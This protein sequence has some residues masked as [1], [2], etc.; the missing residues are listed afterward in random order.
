MTTRP[1]STSVLVAICLTLATLGCATPYGG[2]PYGST[3]PGYYG[4]PQA[5]PPGTIYPGQPIPT[6]PGTVAPGSTSSNLPGQFPAAGQFPTPVAPTPNN[7]SSS[8]APPFNNN[9]SAPDPNAVPDY[10][11]PSAKKPTNNNGYGMTTPFPQADPIANASG[12]GD[13]EEAGSNSE[14]ELTGGS[15][16]FFEPITDET[17]NPFDSVEVANYERESQSA[18][19]PQPT[20]GT[21]APPA[22]PFAATPTTSGEQ[23]P[24]TPRAQQPIEKQPQFSFHDEYRWV[25]GIVTMDPQTK[26]WSVIY[27]NRPDENDKFGGVLT[28]ED[29]PQVARLKEGTLVRLSGQVDY[30]RLDPF[31]KPLYSITE[32]SVLATP[33]AR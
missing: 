4:A 15:D 9:N 26:V 24:I 23:V 11:D 32:V 6:Q 12:D 28:L 17:E 33:A 21:D 14:I 30:A 20:F 16:P 8:G 25:Q 3:Y 10:K 19:R 2:S 22:N 5:A 18:A 13:T 7:N 31:N 27:S 29:H 1:T